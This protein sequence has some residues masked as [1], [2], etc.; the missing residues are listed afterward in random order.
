MLREDASKILGIRVP[1]DGW[2]R[3]LQELW[4]SGR[5]GNKEIKEL[6]FLILRT[7]DKLENGSTSK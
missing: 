3:T 7:L 6:I 1:E 4:T 2:D 5:P